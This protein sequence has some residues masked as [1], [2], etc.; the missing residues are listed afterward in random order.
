LIQAIQVGAAMSRVV[1]VTIPIR[2]LGPQLQDQVSPAPLGGIAS[3][4]SLGTGLA[5]LM[6][7]HKAQS[8][9]YARQLPGLKYTPGWAVGWWFIPIANL[10]MPYLA[11]REL[12]DNVGRP[13]GAPSAGRRDWKLLT[14]WLS[15]IASSYLVLI[16]FFPVLAAVFR[17]I[18]D[19]TALN[20]STRITSITLSAASI[21]AA[22]S[23][24]I[25]GDA[26]R[27]VAAGLAVWLVL[28]ISQ[29]E[30]AGGGAM[31]APLPGFPWPPP[32][33]P[34]RPDLP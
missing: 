29:R 13:P 25:V 14:W 1:D 28:R 2:Q 31:A 5:W 9:L 22:Q 4:L 20:G 6:W 19:Q 32:M 10:F 23:W 15:Y 18:S 21:H 3:L 8:D 17:S 27:V 7:Q 34:P 33:V 30:D 12:W 11:V 26:L 24:T 16:G